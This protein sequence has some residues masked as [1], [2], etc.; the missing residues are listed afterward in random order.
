MNHHL[1]PF[2]AYDHIESMREDARHSRLVAEAR[3]GSTEH[4]TPRIRQ[5][6][7]AIVRAAWVRRPARG[8]I[9][10]GAVPSR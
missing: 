9:G 5:T 4:R 6:L 2:L 8:E 3:A 7:A 10:H 1:S